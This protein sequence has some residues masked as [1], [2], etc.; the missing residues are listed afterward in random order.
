MK[1][2]KIKSLVQ[3]KKILK[4]GPSQDKKAKSGNASAF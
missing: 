1:E 4:G 2:T 3:K